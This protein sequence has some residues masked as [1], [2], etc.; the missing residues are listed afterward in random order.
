M[1][2]NLNEIEDYSIGASDGLIG[3][4]KDGYFDQHDWVIR[5]LVVDTGSWLTSRKVLISPFAIGKPD[6]DGRRL[7]VSL[8][9]QQVKDSPPTDDD[10]PL[11]RQHEMRTLDY[12][13]FPFY[14]GGGGLWGAGMFPSMMLTGDFM[15]PPPAIQ[16]A[17]H[18]AELAE[19]HGS[20]DELHLRSCKM[21]ESFQI[22]ARD[23][24][25]GHVQGMLIDEDTWA[26]RYLIIETG[27]WWL[28]QRVLIAPK[29]ITDVN[30][31]ESWVVVN[32]S[33]QAIQTAPVYDPSA[34]F[35]RT[36]E[37]AI[38]QHYGRKG[39]WSTEAEQQ[40]LASVCREEV[41]A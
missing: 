17:A 9:R 34:R 35:G 20:C 36:Q 22:H 39:Y 25:I 4:V 8:T 31:N 38:H 33:R 16:E 28:G 30:W 13:G 12:Y 40:A 6:W 15:L 21:L 18:A 37:I 5:Y 41:P 32:L 11:T 24:E 27:N 7:P 1:L 14:W 29:W 26:V 19:Q 2:R 3:H 23:G 10:T